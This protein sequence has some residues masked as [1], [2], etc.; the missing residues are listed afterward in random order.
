[1]AQRLDTPAKPIPQPDDASRPFFEGAQRGELMIQRCTACAAYLAPGS[2]A[3]TECL[4]EALEWVPASGRAT[5]FT[6]A[7]MH[8]RYHP[9]FAD[10]LPYNIAVVEL[11][12]GPRLNTTIVGVA[13]AELRVGMPL[14]VTFDEVGDGVVL[15]KFKPME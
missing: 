7:I 11:A 1:M 8:Q 12:E 5:L 10:E 14:T 13:N 4:S 2:R 6:F 3:C 9:G 15:P